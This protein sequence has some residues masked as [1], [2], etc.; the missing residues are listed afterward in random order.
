MAS[1]RGRSD[2]LLEKLME[3]RMT[4]KPLG[5]VE[6]EGSQIDYKALTEAAGALSTLLTADDSSEM[7]KTS[8]KLVLL[9]FLVPCGL[10]LLQLKRNP[11]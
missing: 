4:H 6:C 1:A 8:R 3:W 10:K 11:R 7:S 2:G 5:L 9:D